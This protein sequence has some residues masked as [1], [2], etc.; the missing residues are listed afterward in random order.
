VV[1][2]VACGLW[3]WRRR[4][5]R[6]STGE[7]GSGGFAAVGPEEDTGPDEV[8]TGTGTEEARTAGDG[9]AEATLPGESKET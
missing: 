3:R 4:R 6:G 7:P 8:A 1:A 9:N 2:L 5:A